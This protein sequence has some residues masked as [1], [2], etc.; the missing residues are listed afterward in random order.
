MR[1]LYPNF[2]GDTPEGTGDTSRLRA[3]WF[4]ENLNE[5]VY[6]RPNIHIEEDDIFKTNSEEVVSKLPGA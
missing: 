4:T 3:G 1:R 5:T 6:T 2:F